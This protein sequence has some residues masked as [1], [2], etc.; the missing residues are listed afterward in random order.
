MRGKEEAETPCGFKGLVVHRVDEGYQRVGLFYVSKLSFGYF[1][2]CEEQDI[3]FVD[4]DKKTS[5]RPR[6][7]DSNDA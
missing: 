5:Q 2:G 4:G 1:D 6:A 3:L 7:G